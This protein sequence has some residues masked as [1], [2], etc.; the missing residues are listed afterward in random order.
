MIL[1]V[2]HKL[3][4]GDV[5]G[6]YVVICCTYDYIS[7]S[8]LSSFSFSSLSSLFFFFFFGSTFYYATVYNTC[9]AYLRRSQQVIIE[10]GKD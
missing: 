4:V 10:E 6:V 7:F 1:A 8:S 5:H 3:F 9:T 2:L